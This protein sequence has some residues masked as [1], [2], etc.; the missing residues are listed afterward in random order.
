[1]R[2][3]AAGVG[4]G[5]YYETPCHR[6]KPYLEAGADLPVTD[7]LAADV[8][9]IPV[10]P[11][12]TE[13]ERNIVINAVIPG[14]AA[15]MRA[16]LRMG[17]VGLGSMGRNHARI[18]DRLEDVELVGGVDP[19][20]DPQRALAHR[21]VFPSLDGLLAAGVDAITIAVPSEFHEEVALR[22]AVEGIHVLIEKPLGPDLKSAMRI[23]DAFA[24][25]DLV[26][27][28]GPRRAVQPRP[29]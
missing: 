5:I 29:Q 25:T 26:A 7:R 17:V 27:A 8:L 15:P 6:Q 21:A 11:D 18:A 9:S 22:A 12:L 2:W 10:R 24:G 28:V 13:A 14:W 16:P 19:D 20:G 1:M 3:I 23:R 4:Y